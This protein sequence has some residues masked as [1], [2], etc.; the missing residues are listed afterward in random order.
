MQLHQRY[1]FGVVSS[2]KKKK[3]FT[4]HYWMSMDVKN[5]AFP[6]FK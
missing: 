3:V 2:T 4:V 6:N 1:C 5:M